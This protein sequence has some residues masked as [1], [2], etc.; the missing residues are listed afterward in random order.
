MET[1]T[2]YPEKLN[3]SKVTYLRT[4]TTQTAEARASVA[5]RTIINEHDLSGD[6]VDTLMRE[7]L[8]CEDKM[9]L[10]TIA[11][12]QKLS[13]VKR[14]TRYAEEESD[15]LRGHELTATVKTVD[16]VYDILDATVSL[17]CSLH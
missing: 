9:Q 7:D 10:L 13:M 8:S 3:R 17:Y 1:E 15:S 11:A 5:V 16:E 6:C 12:L 4:A 14:V 2:I